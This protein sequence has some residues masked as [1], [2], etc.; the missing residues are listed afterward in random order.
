MTIIDAI[1]DEVKDE[2]NDDKIENSQI[3]DYIKLPHSLSSTYVYL[4]SSK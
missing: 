2:S 1:L 4:S 3:V